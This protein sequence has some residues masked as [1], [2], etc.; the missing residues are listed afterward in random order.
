MSRTVPT[1][2]VLVASV[3][4]FAIIPLSGW[5]S[6]RYGRRIVY[7][8]F[9][10]LLMLY[11]IPAFALLETRDPFIV[12]AVI[13]VGMGLGSLGIFGVQAAYGVE[14]FGV[15]HRYSKMAVAKELGSILSGGTA[16]MVASALLAATGSWVP[17]AVYFLI[18]ATIGFATT[19]VAPE[20][21]GRDLALL[22]DAV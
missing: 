15:Q 17:L 8:T 7:R 1:T 6:D 4:G 12:G 16:P 21:R 22:E 20:T 9:C 14:L 10:G 19:F 5:L 2:A 11:A 18:M 3:L 13:V